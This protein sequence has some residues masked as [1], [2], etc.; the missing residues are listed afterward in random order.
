MSDPVLVIARARVI[1]AERERFIAAAR[2][3]IAAT[4]REQG[5]L[6]YDICENLTDPGHFVSVESWEK[7]ADVD[8][9]MQQAHLQ[10]FLAI[11]GTC[12]S[13][14]PVIEVVEPR[15]VDRL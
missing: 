4:R 1:P 15:S 7:R 13:A 9:H 2:D 11:A 14:A 10:A 3:C 5:C 12:V 8:R 6:G